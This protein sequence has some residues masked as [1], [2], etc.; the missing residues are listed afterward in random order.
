MLAYC[1]A[2]PIAQKDIETHKNKSQQTMN[3][4]VAI[5]DHKNIKLGDP[6]YL[7]LFGGD[8]G[9][10]FCFGVLAG[11]SRKWPHSV[12]IVKGFLVADFAAGCVWRM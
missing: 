12:M 7:D 4:W 8:L 6:R 11:S 2:N 5:G 10:F 3:E 1:V 9:F